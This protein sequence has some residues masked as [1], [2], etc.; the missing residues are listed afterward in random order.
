MKVKQ[1]TVLSSVAA[2]A[3]I[4]MN[5]AGFLP[6]MPAVAFLNTPAGSFVGSAIIQT[7][8]DNVTWANAAG[9]S[10]VTSGGAIQNITLKQYVRLNCTAFTSGSIQ[11][12]LLSNVG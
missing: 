11:L 9:A 2:S 4:A 5:E 3:G 12:S 6:G 1:S 7:S 10:A 8:E